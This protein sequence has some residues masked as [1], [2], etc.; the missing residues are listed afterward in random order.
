MKLKLILALAAASVAAA[1]YGG[2][3]LATPGSGFSASTIARATYGPLDV[4]VHATTPAD[5]GAG[6]IPADVWQAMLR[7]KGDSD[8]YVQSNTWQPGGTTGW[9]THPGP[10]LVMVTSGTV[11]AYEGDDPSCAPHVYTTGQAFVDEGGGHVH[12]IRNE[13]ATATATTVAVQFVPAG[14]IRRQDAEDPG[15]CSF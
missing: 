10:S 9:H 13:S 14:A 1:V 7:T 15:N 8:V 3:I 5:P 4:R 12:L 6:A 2:T 11:T